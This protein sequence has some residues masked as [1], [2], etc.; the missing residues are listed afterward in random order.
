M[1]L[2]R[3]TKTMSDFEIDLTVENWRELLTER[4]RAEVSL[5]ETYK[6]SY[7]H[8]TDGHNR[9]VLIAKMAETLDLAWAAL[10]AI[11]P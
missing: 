1:S 10:R 2:R 8:G 11:L 5:A 6:A 9:L 3:M 7:Q 4:E